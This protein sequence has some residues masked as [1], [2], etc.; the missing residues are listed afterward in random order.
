MQ[1]GFT[2]GITYATKSVSVAERPSA[3]TS[4]IK[5]LPLVLTLS[6]KERLLRL[7]GHTE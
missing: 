5:I 1:I 7:G 6:I 3:T 4:L 2:R